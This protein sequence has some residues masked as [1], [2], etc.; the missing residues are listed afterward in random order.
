MSEDLHT[1]IAQRLFGWT[2]DG[3]DWTDA[4][5][6]WH[7]TIPAYTTDPAAFV[8]VWRWLETRGSVLGAVYF[9]Y[10]FEEPLRVVCV[11]RLGRH[12]A[13]EPGT[14][15]QDALCRAALDLAAALEQGEGGG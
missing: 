11:V 6:L 4:A 7:R 9:D 12:T 1:Q 5:G 15:W 14:T 8:Q 13:E 3:V 2:C 10:T